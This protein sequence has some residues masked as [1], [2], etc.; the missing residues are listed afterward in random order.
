MSRSGSRSQRS[1][2]QASRKGSGEMDKE[3]TNP[4]PQE[5]QAENGSMDEIKPA[6]NSEETPATNEN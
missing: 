3:E 5:N 2:V 6:R 1:S 4:P